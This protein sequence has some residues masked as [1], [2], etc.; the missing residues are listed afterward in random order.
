[1]ATP[2]Q[3]PNQNF[4]LQSFPSEH[5]ELSLPAGYMGIS[6]LE[7]PAQLFAGKVTQ[8]RMTQR[9]ASWQQHVLLSH[10]RE[11]STRF[12]GSNYA[13]VMRGCFRTS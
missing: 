9:L 1:M 3:L 2:F 11:I 7:I 13:R 10:T 8:R 5:F 4:V 12:N 6:F